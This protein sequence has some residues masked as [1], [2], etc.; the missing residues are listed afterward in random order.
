LTYVRCAWTL[1]LPGF[2][3]SRKGCGPREAGAP[4]CRA[5]NFSPEWP[6]VPRTICRASC[7]DWGSWGWGG[8]YLAFAGAPARAGVRVALTRARAPARITSG[9][10]AD[11]QQQ[12]PTSKRAVA[13]FASGRGA[14]RR[15]RGPP[16]TRH[17]TP[18]VWPAAALVAGF[19][20]GR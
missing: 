14:D 2:G 17:Q 6:E 12:L 5:R 10:A 15:R 19:A 20:G 16:F 8:V 18:L 3:C 9:G 1:S 4:A 7:V 11:G 13:E